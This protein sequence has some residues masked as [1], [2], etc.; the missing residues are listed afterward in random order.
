MKI[1]LQNIFCTVLFWCCAFYTTAQQATLM[2]NEINP[3][4]SSSHDLIELVAVSGGSVNG[5]TIQQGISSSVTLVTL[6][7]VSVAVGDIIV[8]HLTPATAT[9]A[10]PASETVS[11][12]E[13]THA[14]YTANY[15]NA[16]DFHGG[17]TGLTYSN[18]VL[19]VK[20]SA[21]TI[22]DAVAFTNNG[23]AP[24]A[25]PGDVTTVQGQ[26]LWLPSDCGGAPCSYI[27]TPMVESIAVNWQGSSTTPNGNTAQRISSADTDM[28]SDWTSAPQAQT[29]GALNQG[30]VV[31]V[32]EE[33]NSV[34]VSVF[35]NPTTNQLTIDNGKLKIKDVEIYNMIGEKVFQSRF[36]NETTRVS[37]DVSQLPPGIYFYKIIST[38]GQIACG[39]FAVK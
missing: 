2:L 1:K 8:V 10:A 25:F 3:N 32:E 17:A 34:R 36:S 38:Q 22:Q 6:P 26:N 13:Y 35:P 9:G 23:G 31:R 39:R 11:K 12:N 20:D 18:R 24:A 30:Q 19:L 16:W 7:Q 33:K 5:F 28:N 21:G 29:W 37:V 14:A 4:I 15:D 27:S